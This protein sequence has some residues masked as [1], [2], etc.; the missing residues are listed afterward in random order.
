MRE[1]CRVSLPLACI[2]LLF[3]ILPF[4]LKNACLLERRWVHLVPQTLMFYVVHLKATTIIAWE[5]LWHVAFTLISPRVK[6]MEVF[7]PLVW[8]LALMFRYAC[9]II[10]C[11][12]FT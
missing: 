10:L 11:L 7:P 6:Y 1:G 12:R 5:L 8:R 2:F 9:M 4:S 3:I